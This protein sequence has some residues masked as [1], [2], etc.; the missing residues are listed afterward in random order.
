M[1]ICR[2]TA[3]IRSSAAPLPTS[4]AL[5]SLDATGA[6]QYT[7]SISWDINGASIP[8][9]AA[10]ESSRHVH[11]GS[12]ATVLPPGNKSVR[13]LLEAAR[14]HATISFDPNCRTAISPDTAAAARE[15]A[16]DFV[17][18]SDIVKASDEDLR[19]L[20]PDRTLEESI[21]AWLAL[22]PAMVALTRG[23]QGPVLLSRSGRVEMIGETVTVADT[24]GAG[25]SFMAALISGLAQL[26]ALGAPARERLHGITQDQLHAL[27][28]YANKAAGI[29]CSRPGA[30]P[31]VLADLGPLTIPSSVLES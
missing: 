20:Y 28:R 14:P 17:A 18:A 22:G 19:W 1:T 11:T 2:V 5:A 12:I 31:P 21:E 6:A 13:G 7:F 15:Q 25:D 10:A 4:T 24:V 26:N 23:A 9:L 16:E 29:T 27:A 30:N 8:A 3:S